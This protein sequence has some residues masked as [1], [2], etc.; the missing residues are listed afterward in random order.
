MTS[1][2]KLQDRRAVIVANLLLLGIVSYTFR[3]IFVNISNPQNHPQLSLPLP[4]WF[5]QPVHHMLK[6]NSNLDIVQESTHTKERFKRLHKHMLIVAY[7]R[8]TPTWQLECPDRFCELDLPK[9]VCQQTCWLNPLNV[10]SAMLY[11][12]VQLIERSNLVRSP[13]WRVVLVEWLH[14]TIRGGRNRS[15]WYCWWI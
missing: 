12:C 2:P 10:R 9:D 8:Q 7:T 11:I 4:T 6:G 14:D 13:I 5:S 1:H 15:E 3:D